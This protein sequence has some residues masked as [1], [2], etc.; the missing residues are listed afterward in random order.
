MWVKDETGNVAGSH[1]A[2]PPRARSCCTCV[3]AEALGLGRSRSGRPPAGHRLVRQRRDRRGDAGRSGRRGRSRCSSRRGPTPAV[4]GLPRRRWAP[5][6]TRARGAP[7]TRRAT[8]PCCGSARPSTAGPCRSGVQGPENAL[9]L[10]GGRTIGWE[11][12]DRR[13]STAIVLDRVVVQ[14]GGGALAACV[15]AGVSAAGAVRPRRR[16]GARAARRWRRAWDRR[17]GRRRPSGAPLGRADDA[18]GRSRTRRPTGSS[19]TR[20][21]TGSGSFDVDAALR[22]PPGRRAGGG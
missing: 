10:D 12:A 13:R 7:T 15:G 20:P 9:C 22:R 3:A 2:P 8:R 19:T 4:L 5:T 18:V 14:V 16:A 17:A 21:T 1:K 11:M 6:V